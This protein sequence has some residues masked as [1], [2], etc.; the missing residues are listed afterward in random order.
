V[1]VTNIVVNTLART[2]MITGSEPGMRGRVMALYSIV[3]LGSTP[4]GG[5]VV[6]WACQEWGARSAF[7]IA[8]LTAAGAAAVMLVVARARPSGT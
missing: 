2:M 3:F 7:V 1:G 6:G 8:G 5:P 4:I